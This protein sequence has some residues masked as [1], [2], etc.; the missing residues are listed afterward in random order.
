MVPCPRSCWLLLAM[1][2]LAACSGPHSATIP[3][4]GVN[5]PNGG[6]EETLYFD[7]TGHAHFQG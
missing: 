4:S 1:L 5:G 2:A 7:R 6:A 3:V